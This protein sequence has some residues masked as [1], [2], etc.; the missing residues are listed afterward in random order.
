MWPVHSRLICPR[1]YRINSM[2]FKDSSLIGARYPWTVSSEVKNFSVVKNFQIFHRQSMGLP[3]GPA[4]IWRVKP[5]PSGVVGRGWPDAINFSKDG[6]P[7]SSTSRADSDGYSR[8]TP[9]EARPS[10]SREP[11]RGSPCSCPGIPDIQMIFQIFKYKIYFA[12]KL[13]IW[14]I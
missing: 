7:P 9:D 10:S 5:W 1:I 6:G 14:K 13:P 8:R 4:H 11:C 3:L 12:S 2:Q